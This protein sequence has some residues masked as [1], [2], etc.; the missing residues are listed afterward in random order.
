MI[1]SVGELLVPPWSLVLISD[2]A[3]GFGLDF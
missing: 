2:F 3:F 1:G